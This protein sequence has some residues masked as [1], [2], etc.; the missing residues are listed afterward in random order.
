[1]N[2]RSSRFSVIINVNTVKIPVVVTE[3]VKSIC[4][5]LSDYDLNF[6]HLKLLD[7][8]FRLLV[9]DV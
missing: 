5:A 7:V 1:M 9:A 3:L 2:L 6:L 4:F 8:L